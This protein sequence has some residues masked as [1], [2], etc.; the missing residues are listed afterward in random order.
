VTPRAFLFVVVVVFLLLFSPQGEQSV[1]PQDKEIVLQHGVAVV[2]CSWA[3]IS[4]IPFSKTRGHNRLLPF[5]VAAN[6][7]N[8][9][10]PLKLSCAEAVAAILYIVGL[11]SEAKRLLSKFK[12]GPAFFTV[13][14]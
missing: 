14:G 9:G 8:Y 12:W 2:D 3:K 11:R 1:S 5:L 10:R 13:N 6:P 4:E 7:I